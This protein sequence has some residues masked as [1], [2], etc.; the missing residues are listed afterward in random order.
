[1]MHGAKAERRL[2]HFREPLPMKFLLYSFAHLLESLVP[3]GWN[4]LF[5]NILILFLASLTPIA[6]PVPGPDFE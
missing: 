6:T 2:F 3:T 4:S 1:M 5:H